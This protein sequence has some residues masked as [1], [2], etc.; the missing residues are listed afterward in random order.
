[1]EGVKEATRRDDPSECIEKA[2]AATVEVWTRRRKGA[3]QGTGFI[4][5]DRGLVVTACHVVGQPGR[6]ARRV[7]VRLH[8]GLRGERVLPAYVF[9]WDAQLDYALLWLDGGRCPTL[10]LGAPGKLRYTDVVFA[11]GSPY[12]LSNTV[13]RGVVSNPRAS[14]GRVRYIQ[15]DAAMSPGNSGGPLVDEAGRVVGINL[16]VRSELVDAGHFALPIS[17]V[18]SDVKTAIH[19]GRDGCLAQAAKRWAQ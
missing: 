1:M 6:M 14:I 4:V 3:S 2:V 9:R 13:S 19:L 5:A 8:P 7:Q 18:M 15:T 12:G 16:L 11:I 17:Y 10:A